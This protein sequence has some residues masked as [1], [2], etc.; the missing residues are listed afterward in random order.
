MCHVP[1]EA[2]QPVSLAFDMKRRSPYYDRYNPT[3]RP[4]LKGTIPLPSIPAL[5]KENL[6]VIGLDGMGSNLYDH[7]IA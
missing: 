3:E 7:D 6:F 4:W 5:K 1:R 2:R